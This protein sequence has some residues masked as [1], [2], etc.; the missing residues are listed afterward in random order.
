MITFIRGPEPFVT[1]GQIYV[2]MLPDGQPRSA[3]SRQTPENGSG[4]FSGWFAHGVGWLAIPSH[5][6]L[7]PGVFF[8][9][10]LYTRSF[11]FHPEGH[12]A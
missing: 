5:H 10:G 3:Y 12:F 4:F 11:Y 9:F 2:R 6:L 7:G 8:L 1:A